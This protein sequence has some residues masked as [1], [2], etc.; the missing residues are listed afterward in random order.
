MN[1]S[2]DLQSNTQKLLYPFMNASY[3]DRNPPVVIEGGTGVH[4]TDRLGKQYIDG[5][6]GLWNVNVG[7]GRRE[8][9]D[10]IRQQLDKISYYSIFAGTTNQPSID[11]S[12]RLVEMTAEEGMA[13]AFF[14]SGGSEAN[15]AAFKLVRQ[16]WQQIGQP[17]K[18]N[19]ISLKNAY[20]GV[21]LGALSAIGST[22][23]RERFEPLLSW[24]SQV[25][26]PHLY[27]NPFGMT[28]QTE[29]GSLCLTLMEREILYRGAVNVAAIIAE[30]VQ[31]AGGVIV[32]PAN[33]WPG[34]RQLCDKYGIL[35]IAD[36][37]VTGFGRIG[38]IMGCRHWGVKPDIMTF[39]KGRS[40]TPLWSRN[41]Q[42]PAIVLQRKRHP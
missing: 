29:L 30:P 32:P 25:E 3:V 13:A 37:V 5:Q 12:E 38:S 14:S 35:L 8:I 40:K 31:G 23:Y 41:R 11:L 7:H 17:Q 1:T 27:R 4:V 10:A 36:E 22:Y 18:T 2:K 20:H 21:T 39:A 15:E 42:L 19:I 34:L 26:S 9:Q 24:F 28:D 33:Y 6:A 16:Y